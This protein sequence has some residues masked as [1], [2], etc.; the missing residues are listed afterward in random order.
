MGSWSVYCGISQITINAGQQCVLLPIKKNEGEYLPWLPATLPIFGTYDDYGGIEDIESNDNTKL[1][2]DHFKVSIHDFCHFFTRGKIDADDVEQ[3]L[4]KIEEIKEW[5]YMWIDRQVYDFMSKSIKSKGHL[6]F[7]KPEILKLLGFE[8]VGENTNNKTYDP[9]RFCHEWKYEDKIFHSD[10]TWLHYEKNGIYYFNNQSEY[11]KESSLLT[12]INIPEDKL[13]I[14]EKTKHEMW[15]FLSKRDINYSLGYIVGRDRYSFGHLYDDDEYLDLLESSMGREKAQQLRDR[16]PQ[17]K[18][19]KDKYV[20]DY[21]L[22]GSGLC[23]LVI[24]HQNLYPMS[25]CFQPY[26]LY[27]TPQCGERK[28]HQILLDKFA[29]INKSFLD[30]NDE[31]DEE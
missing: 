20:N 25:G 10:N 14:G 7:G 18:F 29:Q 5:D 24:I 22:F 17:P 30:E 8:Y 16:K 6:D 9:K 26:I 12:Y 3:S 19:L 2:E 15:P 31:L 13:W 28:H 11:S 21:S 4:F 27:L 23:E 1:I